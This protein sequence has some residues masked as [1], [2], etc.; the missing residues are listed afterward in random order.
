MPPEHKNGSAKK[1][2]TANGK[3]RKA[4]AHKVTAQ[5]AT[6]QKTRTQQAKKPRARSASGT[7]PAS[8]T[9]ASKTRPATSTQSATSKRP[10]VAIIGAGR[11]GSALA[12]ALSQSGYAVVAL[13]A[14][15]APH[16]RRAARALSPRPLALGATQLA[17]LPDTDLL[18]I[19][20][21]DDQING[22]AVRLA[23]VF[24]ARDANA[25]SPQPQQRPARVALHASG[26]LA[27]DA[28]A[29]LA[30]QAFSLGSLH[31]LVSISDPQSGASNLRGA[32]YCLEGKARALSAANKIVRALGG[33]SFS[34]AARH[35]PL[36]HAA[37]VMS[38]GHLVALFS[39]A[40][41]MLAHCGLSE[42]QASRVLLPLAGSTL[43]NL[44]HSIYP[45][46][47]LTGPFARADFDTL[48]RHLFALREF[49]PHETLPVYIALGR[50]ALRLARGDG[51]KSRAPFGGIEAMLRDPR[52][53][54]R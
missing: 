29:P 9:S 40:M 44:A 51:A 8:S 33:Q 12:L 10:S 18:L 27:S 16:A 30:A 35:K 53:T 39:L 50:H 41:R 52:W 2:K 4:T 48:R 31:P 49:D 14:S 45:A 46:S 42:R 54:L 47:A 36:Y 43:E 7:R 32:F 26:A 28:L 5:Q 3:T 19:T 22:V 1:L 37:A 20:T 38:A 21:P 23:Q 11:L 24:A 25:V 34:I 13:V 15:H 6:T 17:S